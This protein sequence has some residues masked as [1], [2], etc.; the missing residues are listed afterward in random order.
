MPF[1]NVLSRCVLATVVFVEGRFHFLRRHGHF[2]LNRFSHGPLDPVEKFVF[3]M[4]KK[5]FG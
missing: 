2:P 1:G 3:S 5:S 4:D